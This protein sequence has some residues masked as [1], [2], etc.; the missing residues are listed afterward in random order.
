MPCLCVKVEFY[1]G[2]GF[3]HV[4]RGKMVKVRVG[5]C[6]YPKHDGLQGWFLRTFE[7]NVPSFLS[8]VSSVMA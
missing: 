6:L 7:G 3:Y 4:R 2:T 1:D 5:R 8:Y